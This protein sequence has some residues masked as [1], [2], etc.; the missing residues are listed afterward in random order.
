MIKGYESG[1]EN[2]DFEFQAERGNKFLCSALFR[3]FN[4]VVISLQPD[5]RSKW[6]FDPNVAFYYNGQLVYIKNPKLNIADM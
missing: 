1:V 4:R 3:N 5:V 2:I 6:C